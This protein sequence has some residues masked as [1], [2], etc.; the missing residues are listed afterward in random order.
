MSTS[1]KQTI[2]V[3]T[4]FNEFYFEGYPSQLSVNAFISIKQINSSQVNLHSFI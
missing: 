3:Q 1:S 4:E 2:Y